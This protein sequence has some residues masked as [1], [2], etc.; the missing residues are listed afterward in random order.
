MNIPESTRAYFYRL[1]V[2]VLALLVVVGVVR[3]D[4]LPAILEVAAAVLGI[5]SAGLAAANTT[6]KGR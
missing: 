4:D 1:A 2:A 3:G 6:T 5:T